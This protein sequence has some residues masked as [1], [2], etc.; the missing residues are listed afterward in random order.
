MLFALFGSLGVFF[1]GGGAL[2]GLV[3]NLLMQFPPPPCKTQKSKFAKLN[4][5]YVLATEND[6]PSYGKHVLGSIL[7]FFLTYLGIWCVCWGG[8]FPMDWYTTCLRSFSPCTAQKS[9]FPKISF[10]DMPATENDHPSYVKPLL[11]SILC[12]FHPIWASVLKVDSLRGGLA[13][14]NN[15]SETDFF[16][17]PTIHN[18]QIFYMQSMF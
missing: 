3:H 6:H 11:G 15:I 1:W 17:I 9:K 2:N 4:F 5:F 10:F 14:G 12:F 16:D 18:D 13:E 8:G 7:C